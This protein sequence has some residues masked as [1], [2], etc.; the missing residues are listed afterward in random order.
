[1]KVNGAVKQVTLYEEIVMRLLCSVIQETYIKDVSI[2]TKLDLQFCTIL[3]ENFFLF[4]YF[5]ILDL[6][7]NHDGKEKGISC[8]SVNP[9]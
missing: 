1:M 6:F 3:E 4:L 5:A 8:T 2:Y 9:L 7:L